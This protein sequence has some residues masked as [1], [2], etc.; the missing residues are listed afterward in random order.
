MA[1]NPAMRSLLV[2]RA[3][4]PTLFAQCNLIRGIT[5]VFHSN[6]VII[7]CQDRGVQATYAVCDTGIPPNREVV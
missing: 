7:F 3:G 4:S 1:R 6:F 2:E 5:Q